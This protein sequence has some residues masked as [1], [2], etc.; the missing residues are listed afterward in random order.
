MELFFDGSR[1]AKLRASFALEKNAWLLVY[2]WLK[3]LHFTDGYASKIS[4][5]VNLEEC[6]LYGMKSHDYHKFMQTLI[7]L[8]YR[9]LLSKRIWDALTEISY[10]FEIY[11]TTSC[12]HFTLRGLKW[13]SLRQYA[14]WRW[15]S[16][17]HFFTQWS[18]YP[19]IYC[20][21]QKLEAQSN[22]NECIHS[23]G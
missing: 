2:Q 19:Y 17:H 12:K 13:I 22:I 14:N 23:R 18:I 8:A 21:R 20:M 11:A 15:Y 1:V 4:R 3:S 5:L 6:K 16:L 7:P 10:V 9:D